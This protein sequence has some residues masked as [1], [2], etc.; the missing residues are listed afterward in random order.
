MIL[1]DGTGNLALYDPDPRRGGMNKNITRTILAAALVLTTVA[2]AQTP[3][4]VEVEVFEGPRSKRIAP[5]KYPHAERSQG[6][7]GWVTLNFMVD[8]QGKPYEIAVIESTGNQGLENAAVEAAKDWEFEPATLDGRPIDA[9]LTMTV[10]FILTG[11]S[12]ANHAFV[13]A[14]GS[15]SSAI[16]S[17]DRAKADEAKAKLKVQNLYEDAF[18][19]LAQYQ[20][21]RLWGTQL[22]Q[23]LGLKRA[24]A[25]DGTFL[26]QPTFR[27]ALENLLRLQIQEKDFAGALKTW[28]KLEKL[29]T[30]QMKAHWQE[31]IGRIEALRAD[32]SPYAVAGEFLD[33]PSWRYSLF[34]K[35][36]HI[37]VTS[38]R[39]AEI[40]LRC[41]KKYVF[42]KYEPEVQY[43]TAPEYGACDMELAGDPG[44]KFTLTQS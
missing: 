31:P 20:Y 34:R 6:R 22:E 9:G 35:R 19:G 11:D 17:K 16:A 10:S 5:A 3:T 36:F 23:A 40:K 12:G 8:P 28:R 7:D 14:Y 39:I 18:Y 24:V 15:F 4:P 37:A 32:T 27:G 30:P 38:G 43:T 41:D 21:A 25:I 33:S 29:A 2:A 1:G 26:P 42:F 44:T 13:K